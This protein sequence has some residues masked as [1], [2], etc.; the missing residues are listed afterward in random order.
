MFSYQPE[1]PSHIFKQ[2]QN[3]L[4]S[5]QGPAEAPTSCT[6]YLRRIRR[7]CLRTSSTFCLLIW[8][9]L[10]AGLNNQSP[11]ILGAGVVTPKAVCEQPRTHCQRGAL[12]GASYSEGPSGRWGDTPRGD[13]K[14]MYFHLQ[15]LC[16][17]YFSWWWSFGS[18][19]HQENAVTSLT[20]VAVGPAPSWQMWSQRFPY[21]KIL[22]STMLRALW[23]FFPLRTTPMKAA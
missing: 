16:P 8:Q 18:R 12:R 21:G 2:P 3:Q 10:K 1:R 15:V 22:P 11:E 14:G 23:T 4:T 5:R 20:D 13:R 19:I 17:L 7:H 9:E 6:M